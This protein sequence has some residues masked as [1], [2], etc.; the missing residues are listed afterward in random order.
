MKTVNKWLIGIGSVLG[1]VCGV[2]VLMVVSYVSSHNLGIRSEA[3]IQAQY[4]NCQNIL[5]QYSLQI[6]EAAQIPRMQADDLTKIF[7]N[8]LD[9]RY[10]NDG[11]KA[12]FLWLTEQ[13][14]NLDQATYLKVQQ[15]IE[16]GRNKF[17][18]AQTKL[19]DEK[20]V[21][22][23]NLGYFWRGLWLNLAGFPKI[24][25]DDFAIVKSEHAIEAYTTGVDKGLKLR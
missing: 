10:G 24:K 9:A 17:E 25:L 1:V 11:A 19:I 4:T 2:I 8:T 22:Q 12:A 5:S 23:Q 20:R 16:A 13:N 3:N 15:L 21:Y 18:N 6:S 7:T 14:P